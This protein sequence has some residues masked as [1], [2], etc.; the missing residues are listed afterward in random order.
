MEIKLVCS[1]CNREKNEMARIQIEIVDKKSKEI[2]E[3]VYGEV[4]CL[5]C[6][7]VRYKQRI[8]L[9]IYV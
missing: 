4:I 5:E 6:L 8:K 3:I 1:N 7:R 9:R 2:I